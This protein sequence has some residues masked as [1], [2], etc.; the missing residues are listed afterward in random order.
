MFYFLGTGKISLLSLLGFDHTSPITIF[1]D[2]L[3]HILSTLING[4]SDPVIDDRIVTALES[5]T[6]ITCSMMFDWLSDIRVGLSAEDYRT[7]KNFT[8]D[9]DPENFNVYTDL[10]MAEMMIWNKSASKYRSYIASMI[11]DLYD[12]IE[13]ISLTVKHDVI[14]EPPFSKRYLD[15]VLQML[16][17]SL[18]IRNEEDTFRK[19]NM[20]KR[21]LSYVQIMSGSE[22]LRFNRIIAQAMQQ[23]A[24]LFSG[25][26]AGSRI[27]LQITGGGRVGGFDPHWQRVEERRDTRLQIGNLGIGGERRYASTTEDIGS[28][29]GRDCCISCVP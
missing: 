9:L 19:V 11:G 21:Q 24:I 18:E 4:I 13:A 27:E 10:Y 23:V 6:T 29:S 15:H 3:P 14:I 17:E 28:S 26:E 20:A 22:S 1:Y 5:N 12:L 16:K 8:C 2:Q 25:I 7:L